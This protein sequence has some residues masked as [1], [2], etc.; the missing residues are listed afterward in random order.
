ME[1]L[2]LFYL[3]RDL[4]LLPSTPFFTT[5]VYWYIL[6]SL[7]AKGT[8]RG[9]FFPNTPQ[10]ATFPCRISAV[11][12]RGSVDLAQRVRRKGFS[13][14]RLAPSPGRLGRDTGRSGSAENRYLVL[15]CGEEGIPSGSR[16]LFGLP[17]AYSGAL[18]Q[19]PGGIPEPPRPRPLPR[20]APPPSWLKLRILSDLAFF[21]SRIVKHV[22]G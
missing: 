9:C 6:V 19:A 2:L 1:R 5:A 12:G 14:D 8:H 17:G 3:G 10:Q 11:R 20:R 4:C 7:C 15:N 21:A 13:A 22:I 18:P 16:A